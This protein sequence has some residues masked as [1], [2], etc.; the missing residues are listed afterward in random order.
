MRP[1]FLIMFNHTPPYVKIIRQGMKQSKG[2]REKGQGLWGK[3]Q[4]TGGKGL[5]LRDKG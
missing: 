5:G 1:I 2:V 4:G 3:G